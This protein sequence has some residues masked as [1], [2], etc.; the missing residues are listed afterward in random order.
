MAHF[1]FHIRDHREFTE[2]TQGVDLPNLAKAIEEAEL[3]AREM[4]AEMV[5]RREAIDGQ[6][7]EITD[8]NGVILAKV[9]WKNSIII[10]D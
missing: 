8:V 1:Y 6:V 3:A 7:F 2:D 9:V 10:E 4:V 5:L